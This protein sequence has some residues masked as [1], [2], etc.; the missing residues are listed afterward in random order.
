MAKKRKNKKQAGENPALF[1]VIIVLSFIVFVQLLIII[2][3]VKEQRKQSKKSFVRVPVVVS[4]GKPI[5]KTTTKKLPNQKQRKPITKTKKGEVKKKKP[6]LAIILDDWGY[7]SETLGYLKQISLPIDI[8]ILPGHRFSEVSAIQAHKNGKEVMLHLPM[9]PLSLKKSGW[10]K[11]TITVDMDKE[12]IIKIVRCDLENI[13]YVVGV[14]N[15]MGSKATADKRVMRVVLE[16]LKK[17]GMFFVDSLSSANSVAEE[18]GRQ[19]GIKLGK[20]DVFID[21]NSDIE[22]IKSQIRRAIRIAKQKGKAIAIGHNRINTLKAIVLLE[23][24]LLN[25]V[26]L[27]PV[28]EIV[29]ER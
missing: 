6:K 17:R 23:Q 14:N 2:S 8:S 15:H 29:E 13:P 20:R 11:N 12:T 24:E 21:N 16:E 25:Q 22:Y 3:L 28:S 10:E 5:K 1:F 27:V 4:T 9:E 26:E 19:V 7:S 18:V